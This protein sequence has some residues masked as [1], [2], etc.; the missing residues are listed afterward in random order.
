[1]NNQIISDDEEKTIKEKLRDKIP[2]EVYE[3][4][5]NKKLYRLNN[6][7]EDLDKLIKKLSNKLEIL[8]PNI[9]DL[10]D[11]KDSLKRELKERTKRGLGVFSL[12]RLAL[13]QIIK[14]S[15]KNNKKEVKVKVKEKTSK[16]RSKISIK[17]TN[18]I[19][20]T[21]LKIKTLGHKVWGCSKEKFQ[22]WKNGYKNY[23]EKVFPE[24]L[25]EE[26]KTM[27]KKLSGI[28]EEMDET[29]KII[30]KLKKDK[31]LNNSYY[32][33]Q[34]EDQRE[35]LIDQHVKRY[36]K[37]L[38][39]FSL[40]RLAIGQIVKKSIKKSSE[41]AELIHKEILENKLKEKT[42]KSKDIKNKIKEN[43]KKIEKI[44]KEDS[45]MN[46]YYRNLTETKIASVKVKK[47]DNKKI[48][49]IKNSNKYKKAIA[50]IAVIGIAAGAGASA[51]NSGNTTNTEKNKTDVLENN[52]PIV[53]EE[54]INKNTKEEVNNNISLNSF[55]KL[56]EGSKMYET[57]KLEGKV[58]IIGMN[59]YNSD[60]LFKINAIT[61]INSNNEITS[62]NLVQKDNDSKN[63][64][65]EQHKEYI[66][67]NP[68]AIVL[69]FHIVPC[70]NYGIDDPSDMELGGWT[71]N[72]KSAINKIST[73]TI[74]QNAQNAL[75]NRRGL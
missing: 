1:M 14:N 31:N 42:D 6:D 63:K 19:N 41:F 11:E 17:K 61:Y 51:I 18:A 2:D 37:G 20:T 49:E 56:D 55:V 5:L 46:D 58:G 35:R 30:N 74:L 40:S 44:I 22:S 67:N 66:K 3:K 24:I 57:S 52:S 4:T 7:I 28:K 26:K 73:E 33:K 47:I 64:I 65:I 50:A 69:N 13:N 53:Q 43:N 27:K 62:F 9:V 70:D 38:G 29:L 23:L 68:N 72:E 36:N 71:N 15:F 32:M 16:L 34:V 75:Q 10:M 59:G 54:H 8:T 48:D 21:N 60:Q 39:I 25:S 12:S 45:N